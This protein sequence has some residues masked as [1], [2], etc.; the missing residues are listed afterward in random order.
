[1]A[2]QARR[3]ASRTD[4]RARRAERRLAKR[5]ARRGVPYPP[6]SVALVA[7]KNEGRLELWADGG[8][9]FTFVRSYLVQATSGRLGPKLR[10][11]DHQVPEGVYR[12]SALNPRSRYHLSLRL[13][14]PNVFDQARGAEDG[15]TTLGGDIMIHGDRVSDGCL[16]SPAMRSRQRVVV[17]RTPRLGPRLERTPAS[18]PLVVQTRG[19]RRAPAGCWIGP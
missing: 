16:P 3:Q 15:R 4:A 19:A 17:S 1:L 18:P 12:V 2:E 7:L 10:Q 11:G 9:G 6:Q 8:A 5:F 14:Y 13:D